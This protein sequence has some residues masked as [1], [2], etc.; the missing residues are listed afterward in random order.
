VWS[1]AGNAIKGLY[2]SPVSRI[3]P[4]FEEVGVSIS[5]DYVM[6]TGCNICPTI[7]MPCPSLG[8]P[9]LD[10]CLSKVCVDGVATLQIC[11]A[12]TAEDRCLGVLLTYANG[13]KECLG[14][15]RFDKYVSEP[16]KAQ[17]CYF[18]TQKIDMIPCVSVRAY[19]QLC[20]TNLEQEWAKFPTYGSI[21]WWFGPNGDIIWLD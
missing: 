5:N 10:W 3:V 14:Q 19:S 9:N 15:I 11:K 17:D 20:T 2:H 6:S 12:G 21:S 4:A 16:I 7:D 18:L 1:K 8:A 13:C